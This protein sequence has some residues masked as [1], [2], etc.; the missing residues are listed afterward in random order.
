MVDYHISIVLKMLHSEDNYLHIQDDRLS[1]VLG[2]IDI[3][4]K[5]NLDDLV[6]VAEKLLKKPVSKVDMETGLIEPFGQ[7]SNEDA[8][9]R[10][11]KILSDEKRHR[12]LK[13][14]TPSAGCNSK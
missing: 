14:H 12:N 4:T 13:S 2:S 7:G 9:K 3:A 10:F 8:L 6:E 1:G 5:K 11:A